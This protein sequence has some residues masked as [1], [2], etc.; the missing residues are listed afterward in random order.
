MC[1]CSAG[2]CSARDVIATPKAVSG[3]DFP[4]QHQPAPSSKAAVPD[5]CGTGDQRSCEPLIPGDLRRSGGGDAGAGERLQTQMKL[6]WPA[7]HLLLCGPVP[8]TDQYQSV[9]Q[10]LGTPAVGDKS[11]GVRQNGIN[12]HNTQ[13]FRS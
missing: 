11:E 3:C 8:D 12:E 4:L 2:I 13:Y 7:A 1:R 9:A 5:L 6:R 10:G